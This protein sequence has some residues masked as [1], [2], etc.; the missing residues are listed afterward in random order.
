MSP[1]NCVGKKN[2]D[3]AAGQKRHRDA[4]QWIYSLYLIVALCHAAAIPALS[5]GVFGSLFFFFSST[6]QSSI[7]LAAR[8]GAPPEAVYFTLMETK[9]S[10]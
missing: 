9:T 2:T 7:A 4:E 1:D 5:M 8:Y 10:A 3:L 6:V